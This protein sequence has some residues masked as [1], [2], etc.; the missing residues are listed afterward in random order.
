MKKIPVFLFILFILLLAILLTGCQIPT[1]EKGEFI[2]TETSADDRIFDSDSPSQ[3][4]AVAKVNGREIY[5]KEIDDLKRE[6]AKMNGKV[7]TDAVALENII[8]NVVLIQEAEKRGLTATDAEVETM[9]EEQLQKE[10]KSISDLKTE[11]GN[12]YQTV[13]EN[14]KIQLLM[15]KLVASIGKININ[16]DDVKSFYEANKGIFVKDGAQMSFEE[17]RENIILFMKQKGTTQ[18]LGELA[19]KLKEKAEI[20]IY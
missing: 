3:N 12:D 13:I 4:I 7:M 11:L 15:S 8:L 16:E 6:Y 17:V 9:F 18:Y 5:Q 2:P 20:E 14:N 1:N 19:K 10:G